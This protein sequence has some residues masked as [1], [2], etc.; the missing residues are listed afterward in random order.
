MHLAPGGGPV[1]PGGMAPAVHVSTQPAGHLHKLTAVYRVRFLPPT[2]GGLS[3]QEVPPR[4]LDSTDP[5]PVVHRSGPVGDVHVAHG[6]R[7]THLP[8]PEFH[9]PTAADLGTG[10]RDGNNWQEAPPMSVYTPNH[11][12]KS[13]TQMHAAGPREG[14]PTA[15]LAIWGPQVLQLCSLTAASYRRQQLFGAPGCAQSRVHV[16][17]VSTITCDGTI[18]LCREERMF[19]WALPAPVHTH[20]KTTTTQCPVRPRRLRRFRP[21]AKSSWS[22]EHQLVLSAMPRAT[23]WSHATLVSDIAAMASTSGVART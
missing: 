9:M 8:L 5:S 4:S 23:A 19:K 18:Y 3:V 22:S 15:D 2:I 10:F 11:R 21:D 7:T 1:Q 6:A 12:A 16:C 13:R 14:V 17:A 20:T